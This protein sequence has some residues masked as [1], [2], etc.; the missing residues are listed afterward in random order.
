VSDHQLTLRAAVTNVGN[1]AYWAKP[2]Y[3][4][5]AVGAPRTVNLSATVDF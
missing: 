4:S 5:L 3:T 1:K 2:H